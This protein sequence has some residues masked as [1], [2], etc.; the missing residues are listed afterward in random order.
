VQTAFKQL[1]RRTRTAR[2]LFVTQQALVLIYSPPQPIIPDAIV[3]EAKQ[4]LIANLDEQRILP[5][6]RIQDF[7][8]YISLINGEVTKIFILTN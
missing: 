1:A 5:E 4:T 3:Q 6:M 2:C 8:S 7:D